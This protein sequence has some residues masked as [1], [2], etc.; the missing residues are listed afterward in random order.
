MLAE[1]MLL[2]LLGA[3]SG[4]V[5]G[6]WASS[7]FA[8]SLDLGTDL[9]V[10]LDFSFDWRVFVYGMAAAILTGV[11]IGLWPAF[12]ASQTVAGAALHEGGRSSSGGRGR[13]RARSALVVG[14]VAGSLVL[15]IGA[16][17]FVRSL[18]NAERVDLG[19]TPDHVLNA[20]LN[21]RWAGY[22]V[23]RSK[24]FYRE[25][26]RRI[27]AWPEVQSA[28]FAFS[29]P[30]GYYS[31][32]TAIHIDEQPVNPG[33]QPPVIG[34]N[35]IDSAYFETMHIPIVRGR[36][37]RESDSE[38][39]PLVAIVNQT[40]ASRF[41]PGQDPIGKRFHVRT[42]DAPLTEVVGVAK[43]SKYLALFEGPLPYF[44]VPSDQSFGPMRV[45]QI[46]SSV[47][48]EMLGTRLR[49]EIEAVDPNVPVVDLQT[50][51]RSLGGAFGFLMFRVGAIQAG[52]LGMLGLALAVI[53]VYGVVSYGAAQRTREI[54]IRMA[55]GATPQAILG[56]ILRHGVWMVLAGIVVGLAGAAALTRLLARFL[57]L[58]SPTDPFTF[59]VV[60]FTLGLVALAACYIPARRAMRVEPVEAL[61]HE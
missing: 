49:Q 5:L 29:V 54:G 32:G 7:I 25:L 35:F 31:A 58:V 40:M 30:L 42:P 20:T 13:Q 41:W 22:D 34:C 56:I 12:R 53:G 1:S 28:T 8:D 9:P 51:S 14:Q 52:L 27:R 4:M 45:L 48:S 6:N 18:Q 61:R 50:M 44:Y 47:P 17:L 11:F 16:G 3:A 46:R 55:L 39:A 2:A 59:L 10:R 60:T 21:P 36:A 37:F 57:L 19:F 26:G 38:T 24:D 43:D 15:L 23:Q 33:E